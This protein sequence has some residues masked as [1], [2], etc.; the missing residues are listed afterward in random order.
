M[1]TK[2]LLLTSFIAFTTLAPAA[3]RGDFGADRKD[4]KEKK[5]D[6]KEEEKKEEIRNGFSLTIEGAKDTAAED[7]LKTF[8]QS[9][10]GTL[11]VKYEKGE[12]GMEAI[13]STK[14][15]LSRG[16]ISKAIKTNKDLKVSEFK[17]L[18]AG[19][20]KEEKKDEKKSDKKDDKKDEK[21]DDK[22]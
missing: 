14:G 6:K 10:E 12:K 9:V 4:K 5:D 15:R 19:W 7:E 3:D 8:L 18:R 13:M 17:A 2:L 1:K 22:K 20:D 21:K 16:D 11:I